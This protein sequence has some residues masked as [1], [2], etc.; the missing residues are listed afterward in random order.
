[1]TLLVPREPSTVGA[2]R[3]LARLHGDELLSPRVTA[4]TA[5]RV[6]SQLRGDRRTVALL[7]VLPSVLLVL[8]NQMYDSKPDFD[9]IGLMLLGIFPFT[10]MFLITSVAMLRERTSG[11][12]E[13]LL[14]TPMTK[15]DLLLGYGLAF[16][17]AAAAQAGVTCATAYLLLD[18]YAPGS[19]VLVIAIAVASA[20][21]GMALGL[22]CSAFATSEFQAVQFMPAVVM[23]QVLLGGLF[24]PRERM[25][26]WLERVSDALPLTYAID[27]L[28]EVGKT[29]LVTDELLADIGVTIG[30]AL[31]ALA[32][33]ASTLRRRT[34]ELPRSARTALLAVPVT[35]LVVGGAVAVALILD[36]VRYVSTDNARADG[37][38]ISLTAPVEG[39]VVG[40]RATEGSVLRKDQVIGRIE[41]AGG[42][43]RVQRVVRA[44][45]DGT[46]ARANVVE[47]THVT[48]GTE[49]AV[50]YDLSQVDVVAQV[51]ETDIGEVRVGHLV[52]VEVD[53]YPGIPF[54]GYVR[55]IQSGTAAEFSPSPQAN[56]TGSFQ[57]LTQVIPVKIAISHQNDSPLVPGMNV[58][59]KIHKD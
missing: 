24:V 7:L 20:V 42:F 38:K 54:T 52:D 41:M 30:A 12:L 9:R 35:A 36:A 28:D 33:A 57:R 26:D 46:V 31:A 1:M 16:T 40:W 49:L 50:A 39:T 51:D 11:T 22:L 18:L 8:I 6:L 55:E 59:V 4:A 45:A 3:V 2:R 43:A 15:L 32:L 19:P 14:T 34:G 13:R 10:I 23:P 29:S 56:T 25:A 17:V 37:D 47:G 53:A 5:R 44:P 58:T 48:P 21:L 27:A